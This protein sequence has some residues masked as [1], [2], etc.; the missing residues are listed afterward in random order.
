MQC[1]LMK[2][3]ILLLLLLLFFDAFIYLHKSGAF[4]F[5]DGDCRVIIETSS[6]LNVT[7]DTHNITRKRNTCKNKTRE[8]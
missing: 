4:R 6:F 1:F 7:T 3:K 5:R 8:K 2:G